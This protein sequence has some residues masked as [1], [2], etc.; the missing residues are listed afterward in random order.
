MARRIA[1]AKL[2]VKGG[3]AVIFSAY[4][5]HNE[6]PFDERQAFYSELQDAYHSTSCHGLKV[7]CGD[8]NARLHKRLPGEE[9]H[10]GEFMYGN[11][12]APLWPGSNRD[13]LMEACVSL[14]L[15]IGNT[16]H[17]ATPREQVTFFAIAWGHT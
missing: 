4:A 13:L 3:K 8:L 6:R 2:R 9:T 5:P 17:E 7:I 12:N 10:V 15:V 11:P 1:Y 16:L 14:D